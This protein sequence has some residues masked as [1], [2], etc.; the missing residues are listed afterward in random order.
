LP[1]PTPELGLEQALD[2]DDTADYQVTSLA[3]SLKT[4]DSL[5]SNASGHTHGGVHQGGPIGSIP[6]T[7]IPDG[8]ITS[9]KIADG[10][11]ATVDLAD[12]S[13]VAAKLAAGAVTTSAIA[14]GVTLA[15]PTLTSPVLNSATDNTPT[16]VNP[17]INGTIAGGPTFSAGPYTSDWFR[18]ST[19]GQ[20]LFNMPAGCGIGF[21]A[22]GPIISGAY[23]GGHLISESAAQTLSNKTLSSP[24]LAGTVAGQPAWGS[25]QLLPS[26]SQVGGNPIAGLVG[27]ATDWVVDYGVTALITVP[28]GG[29]ANQGVSFHRAFAATPFILVSLQFFSGNTNSLGQVNV[30]GHGPNTSGFLIDFGNN[31]GGQQSMIA[32]WIAIGH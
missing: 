30:M 15:T 4:I 28:N 18:V 22:A 6:A 19:A 12:G 26:L 31:S 21:D 9:A 32:S 20:G 14:S 16:I 11:I 7:A 23:A 8:S 24:T 2:A 27:S 13:V 10:S 29:V 25:P 5:F 1:T 17:T 3:N